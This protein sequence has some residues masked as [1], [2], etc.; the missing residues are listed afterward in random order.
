MPPKE[1]QIFMANAVHS[2][3]HSF[4]GNNKSL[5]Y[6]FKII[7]STD[8]QLLQTLRDFF[9]AGSD[10]TA[11]TLRWAALFIVCNPGVQSKMRQEIERVV[12]SGRFPSMEDKTKL[13]YCE[14]VILETQRLGNI[15]PF[16][17]PHMVKYDG[18]FCNS[19]CAIHYLIRY[20]IGYRKPFSVIHN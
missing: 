5:T 8:D 7:F 6:I 4:R 1:W 2:I 20:W 11:A 19:S 17:V 10:T 13:P 3:C 12:G 15:A 14:A 16:A 18:R 9:V